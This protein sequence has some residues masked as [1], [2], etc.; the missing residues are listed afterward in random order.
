MSLQSWTKANVALAG[1]SRLA[2]PLGPLALYLGLGSS[3]SPN[4]NWWTAPAALGTM[5]AMVV[6]WTTPLST[7]S[8]MVLLLARTTPTLEFRVN[9]K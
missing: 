8:L 6:L 1:P 2:H 3:N 7:S 5:D 4:N 9:A